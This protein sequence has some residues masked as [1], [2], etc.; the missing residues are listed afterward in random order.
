VVPPAFTDPLRPF[1][2]PP[3]FSAKKGEAGWGPAFGLR[4][5]GRTRL[6]YGV[7]ASAR[8]TVPVRD[9]GAEVSSVHLLPRTK[10]QLSE[11]WIA[12]ISP[13]L[14]L[15]GRIIRQGRRVSRKMGIKNG[16]D[17]TSQLP[18]YGEFI[19]SSGCISLEI[20]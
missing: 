15:V 2:T 8:A 5:N 7:L 11:K 3:P 13:G 19:H 17:R 18:F 14:F 12:E 16:G 20:L 6:F 4:A 9:A 1:G 10:R